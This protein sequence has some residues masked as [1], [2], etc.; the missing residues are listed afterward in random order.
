M[1]NKGAKDPNNEQINQQPEDDDEG[2]IV[3]SLNKHNQNSH[4]AG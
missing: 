4:A 3:T 2:V 1:R